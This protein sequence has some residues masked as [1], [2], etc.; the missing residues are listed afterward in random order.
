[1]RKNKIFNFILNKWWLPIV[2]W[3]LAFSFFVISEGINRAVFNFITTALF[4]IALITIIISCTVL[5]IDKKWLKGI[6][7]IC[8]FVGI[9]FLFFFFSMMMFLEEQEQPEGFATNLKIPKNIAIEEPI[10]L[11]LRKQKT[12]SVT[13]NKLAKPYFQLYQDFQ[14]GLYEYDFW[15]GKIEKGSIYLKAFEITNEIELSK[16]KLLEESSIAVFNT[17]N[18]IKKFGTHSF[19]TIYEGDWG[20][21]YAARFEI[22]FKPIDGK[23]E[24]KLISK[25]YKIEGWM[26]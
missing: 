26:Q 17:S 20:Q 4:F 6:I 12:D 16:E 24:R 21:P 14:P 13:T 23:E 25:N 9:G 18:T 5:I 3:F 22:W 11:H 8:A 2:L 19:F 10:Q 1:M 7:S 15:V